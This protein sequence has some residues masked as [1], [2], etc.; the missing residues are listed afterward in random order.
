MKIRRIVFLIALTFYSYF[1][2]AQ[3]KSS[4]VVYRVLS[5]T[6]LAN[7]PGEENSNRN[8]AIYLPPGYDNESIRYPVVYWAHGFGRPLEGGLFQNIDEWQNLLDKAISRKVIDPIIMVFIDNRTEFWGS[9][10]A[11]S[12]L[13]GNWEDLYTQELV[14]NIDSEYRTIPKR[15]SRAIAGFSMGGY[16][17][18]RLAMRNP[19]VYSVV[20]SLSPAYGDLSILDKNSFELAYHSK[21]KEELFESFFAT[22]RIAFGRTFTPNL[23]NPPFYCDLPVSFENDEMIIHDDILDVW[24]ENTLIE[25]IENNVSS[26]RKLKAIRIEWGRFDIPSIIVGCESITHKLLSYDIDHDAEEFNGNH[27]IYKYSDD[28]RYLADMLPFLARNLDFE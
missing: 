6:S 16:G 27:G 25:L 15:E 18:L 7:N 17:A 13:T 20:Y 26:L 10:Y 14:T 22:G 3:D 21:T 28:G 19:D 12:E 9:W 4:R 23:D 5:S 8:M 24:R 2:L 1:T 11:N